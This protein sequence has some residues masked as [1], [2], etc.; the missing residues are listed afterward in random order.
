MNVKL[1]LNPAAADKE[2]IHPET[3]IRFRIRPISPEEY[4]EIIERSQKKDKTL[5]FYKSREELAVAAIA[6]WGKDVGDKSGPLDCT[7]ANLRTFGRRQAINIM[8]WVISQATGLDQ[9]RIEEE[10]AAKN[11]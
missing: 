2:C 5:D 7:E 11:A 9:Y 3:G 4:D 10:Q 8:P 1:L 6:D